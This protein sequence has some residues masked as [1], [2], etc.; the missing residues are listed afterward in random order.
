[1]P[2]SFQNQFAFIVEKVEAIRVKYQVSLEEFE[3][4]YDSLSQM[5]FKG[6]LD[7]S[8]VVVG[9]IEL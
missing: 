2:H 7:L 3:R 5:A 1:M 4:L 8:G 9:E 6:E